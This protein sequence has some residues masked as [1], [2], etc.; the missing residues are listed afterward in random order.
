MIVAVGE[1]DEESVLITSNYLLGIA[2]NAAKNDTRG[3]PLLSGKGQSN[4]MDVF[5]QIK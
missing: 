3:D 4:R 1:S 5:I 2:S